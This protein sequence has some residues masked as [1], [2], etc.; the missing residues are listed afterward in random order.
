MDKRIAL[1]TGGSSGIGRSMCL[2]LAEE[3]YQVFSASRSKSLPDD[4]AGITQIP[5]DF[6][7]SAQSN[8]FAKKFIDQYGVPDLLVNNAGYGAFYELAEFPEAEIINQ[9]EVLFSAP[10]R[11]CRIFAPAMHKEGRGLIL[12]LSS[13]AT[14]Y[15]LPYMYMYNAGKSALSSFTGSMM[16]EYR[17]SPKFIDFRMGDVRTSFNTATFRQETL[18]QSTSA[19]WE[20]IEKQLNDSISIETAVE[21]VFAI[22]NKKKSGT[23][24]GGTF[25]HRL[26]LPLIFRILPRNCITKL[27]CSWYRL[28]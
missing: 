23:Y 24:Y 26:V 4:M 9:I 25:F 2:K 27:I 5:V 22:I 3:G 15:P 16:L 13:L 10:V 19:A 28:A 6:S 21:Q 8:D 12:N 7:S 14:L 18:N 17:N 1:V 20:Q 11:L